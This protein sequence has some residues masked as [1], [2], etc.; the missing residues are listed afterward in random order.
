MITVSVEKP[1][2][3]NEAPIVIT[4]RPQVLTIR[5]VYRTKVVV[6]NPTDQPIGYMLYVVPRRLVQLSAIPW[7]RVIEVLSS[8]AGRS[9]LVERFTQLLF[10][11]RRRL[12]GRDE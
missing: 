9:Q 12:E 1:I 8:P 11:S 7:Q 3:D 2:K 6:E 4:N 5:A 10:D